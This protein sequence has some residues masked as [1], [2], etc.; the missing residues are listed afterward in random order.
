MKKAV[1]LL[2]LLVACTKPEA[3]APKSRPNVLV[4]TLDTTRYD[5]MGPHTPSFNALAARGVQFRHAYATVPQTLP[6]HA[7]MFTGLY[8]A[9]HGVHENGRPLHEK[10]PLIAEK[11]KN[12]GYATGAFVSAFALAKRFGLARGFDVYDEPSLPE[13]NAKETTDRALAWLSSQSAGPLFLWVHYYDPHYPYT[14]DYRGEV[15]F[16]DAELGRLVAAFE[17]KGDAAI[18]VLA[19]HGE[20][21]GEHG[22]QQHGNLL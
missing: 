22:E 17:G 20:G 19:D 2:L 11:L 21:L 10:H 13:R 18:I 6:S 16:M 14:P 12:A 1:V 8:P 7:S 15:A 3:P 5:A 9:G 4:V